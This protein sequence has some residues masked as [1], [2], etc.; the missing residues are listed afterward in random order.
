[1]KIEG[2][3]AYKGVWK[4]RKDFEIEDLKEF[5]HFVKQVK[6]KGYPNS[7]MAWILSDTGL[8]YI[9]YSV[10][11]DFRVTHLKGCK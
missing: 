11:Y 6:D 3:T 10:T 1:M 8:T 9:L 7:E 5:K 4:S 2:L